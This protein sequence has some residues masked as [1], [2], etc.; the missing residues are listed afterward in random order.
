MKARSSFFGLT[1]LLLAACSINGQQEYEQALQLDA[2]QQYVEAIDYFNQ[3]LALSP[4]NPLY[5]SKLA[6]VKN[7]LARSIAQPVE[8]FLAGQA[9]NI[10]QFEQAQNQ[11]AKVN[12]YA[13]EYAYQLRGELADKR[14]NFIEA[15]S[16][17]Y[18]QAQDK[19]NTGEWFAAKTT[20]QLIQT[21]YP[22]FQNSQA[23]LKKVNIDGINDYLTQANLA[24]TNEKF[25]QAQSLAEQALKLDP[26]NEQA[27]AV[28][29]Q[30]KQ[31]NSAEYFVAQA[32]KAEKK[33]QWLRAEIYYKKAQLLNPDDS[34]IPAKITRIRINKELT[35][36]NTSNGYLA[37]GYL[38]KAYQG[39]LQA[40][41][42]G[43]TKNAVQLN[44]LK[45][46]LSVKI[47]SAADSLSASQHYGIALFW[48]EILQKLVPD[49]PLF[50][51]QIEQNRTQLKANLDSAVTADTYFNRAKSE[52]DLLLAIETLAQAKMSA[53]NNQQT[54]QLKQI[55][56][57]LKQM[58]M[59][60]QYQ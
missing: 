48:Y 19:I 11:L 59:R 25:V 17:S 57:S 38:Y 10:S 6:E 42:Y 1:I 8:K 55:D 32:L 50:L 46:F 51:Q 16:Q 28:I 35:L 41:A 18:Q 33:K 53:Q 34:S 31:N 9:T 23:L 43:Y 7:K 60:Y 14:L 40:K 52:K 29:E 49:N 15:L 20:L 5:L 4:E 54:E 27:S 21:Q 24:L 39:Y 45:V 2:N 3:A 56:E 47:N 26:A 36:I 13:P 44:A 12:Q 37:D 22:D 58:M 30:A